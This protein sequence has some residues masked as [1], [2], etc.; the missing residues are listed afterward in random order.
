M[1]DCCRQ[2]ES[3]PTSHRPP[4]RIAVDGVYQ[5]PW[6]RLLGTRS[7]EIID[8]NLPL[9]LSSTPEEFD[10]FNVAP[11]DNT[12]HARVIDNVQGVVSKNDP[13]ERILQA[14]I[15]QIKSLNTATTLYID[16]SYASGTRN[17]GAAIIITRGQPEEPLILDEIKLKGAK[18][19]CSNDEQNQLCCESQSGL[20]TTAPR[21]IMR[22]SSL[23]HNHCVKH[24]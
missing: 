9:A 12:L 6:E 2:G 10:L 15:E 17:G 16:G 1:S 14:S 11:W 3:R 21:V 22:A 23:I 20:L 8:D 7:A 24:S 13:T 4:R 19:T 18:S 5:T